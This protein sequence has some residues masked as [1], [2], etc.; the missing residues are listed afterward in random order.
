MAKLTKSY[1]DRRRFLKTA[2]LTSAASVLSR[3]NPAV[4]DTPSMAPPQQ[5]AG[6]SASEPEVMTTD[7]PGADFMMD[8]LKSLKLEYVCGNPGS[9]YRGL[10][11]SI[12]NYGGNVDPQFI[13]C[14]HEESAVAMGHGYAKIEGKPLGV[15]VHGVVGLQHAAM[16]IYNAYC[17]RVPVYII[18][19]NVLDSAVRRPALDFIH[20]AQDPAAFVRDFVKWDDQPGSLQAYA[21][22]AIRGYR[23]AMT[24][25]MMPVLLVTDFKLQ[26]DPVEKRA[27][28]RI[29]KMTLPH[30]PQGDAGAVAEAARLLVQTDNPVIVVDRTARTQAGMELLVELAETLQAP[31]VDQ[32]SRMNI[33]SRHPLNQSWRASSLIANA[34]VVL[35]MELTDFW[36]TVH[37][38]RDQLERTSKPATREGT[39]LINI[40]V[41]SLYMKANVQDLY[42]F[43]EVDVDISADAEATLPSLIEAVKRE[44]TSD[45]RHVYERRGAK[46]AEDRR[47]DLEQ[48]RQDAMYGWD[49]SPITVGRVCAELWEQ[50]QNEDWSFVSGTRLLSQ[51]P[52]RLWDFTKYYQYIGA[53]GGLGVGYNAPAATGAALANRKHGRLT[54]NIQGDGDLLYAPAVLFT[55]AHYRIP[56]LHIMHNNRAY[57]AEAMQFQM[58]ACRHQRG[59]DNAHFPTSIT[60]PD[61]DFAK[62]AQGFGIHA[63]GPIADPS[64]LGGAIARAIAV[65]KRGEPALVDVVCQCR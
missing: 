64:E 33:P 27:Q 39:K 16:A 38:F 41:D 43:E 60:D 44:I 36:G 62:I 63:E 40:G 29:P 26:E 56:V 57:H 13:M 35:G 23:I 31:V 25:P 8:I 46:F 21:E 18:M 28:P 37:S 14:C 3:V 22:S 24:P 59:I 9:S 7:R 61:I 5:I 49:A 53:S 58:M 30:P 47:A 12:I 11:E 32:Y 6:S 55:A 42:R 19:G 2:A 4:G 1:V 45:R 65:V 54:V 10:Y 52:Q 48:A 20:S 34:D 17:D 51:W 50:I 15:F